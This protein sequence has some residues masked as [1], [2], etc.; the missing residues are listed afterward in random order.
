M[1]KAWSWICRTITKP[2]VPGRGLRILML[3][4]GHGAGMGQGMMGGM[5]NQ[6][7]RLAD[8]SGNVLVDTG[9]TQPGGQLS[10]ADLDSAVALQDGGRTVGY[11]LPEGGIAFGPGNQTNLV[12]RLTR[13]AII[14]GLIA[15]GLSLVLAFLLAFG[16][17]KPVQELT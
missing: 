4:P 14:S 7:M 6:R 2:M 5:M 3:T 10:Q 9:S 17:N 13:S 11:L 1:Y 16:L 8:A 12:N 15:A